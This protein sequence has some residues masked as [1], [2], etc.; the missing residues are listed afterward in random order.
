MGRH[1]PALSNMTRDYPSLN[2]SYYLVITS[3]TR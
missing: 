3:F 1:K 2:Y